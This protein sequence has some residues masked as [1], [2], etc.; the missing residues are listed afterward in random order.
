MGIGS[1]CLELFFCAKN[2]GADFRETM[3]VGRQIVFVPQD[4]ITSML[5][6][7]GVSPEQNIFSS[8]ITY[9]EP[10]FAALGAK[11][12]SSIDASDYECPTTSRYE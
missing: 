11:T 6:E 4:T 8:D 2:I 12:V 1:Q 9:G 3:M 7:A 5:R 10:I